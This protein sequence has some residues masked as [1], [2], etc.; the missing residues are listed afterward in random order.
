[1]GSEYFGFDRTGKKVFRYDNGYL[2]GECHDG[3]ILAKEVKKVDVPPFVYNEFYG[4]I[5]KDNGE[6][7]INPVYKNASPFYKKYAV[8]KDFADSKFYFIS[9]SGQRIP[10]KNNWF[11]PVPCCTDDLDS[12]GNVIQENG[13]FKVEN[14]THADPGSLEEDPAHF[15]F[16]RIFG[17]INAEGNEV[18]PVI[19]EN[20]GRFH[21]NVCKV[22]MKGKCGLIDGAGNKITE[23][24]YDILQVPPGYDCPNLIESSYHTLLDHFPAAYLWSKGLVKV[25]IDGKAGLVDIYGKEYFEEY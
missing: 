10:N 4:Y 24:K 15:Q 3:L 5:G 19:Y 14:R 2:I 25:I 12:L 6:Y 1:L 16:K 22:M 17:F 21:N 9:T 13:L 18:I 8:V 7:K 20:A 11:M 23:I